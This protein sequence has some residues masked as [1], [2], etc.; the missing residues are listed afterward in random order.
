MHLQE[1]ELESKVNREGV[2]CG[3]GDDVVVVDAIVLIIVV[4]DDD[5]DDDATGSSNDDADEMGVG[6]GSAA[7]VFDLQ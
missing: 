3:G 4:V 1:H 6:A 2:G 5:D 7:D